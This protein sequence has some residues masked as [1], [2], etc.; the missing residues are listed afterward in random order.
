MRKESFFD[1]E[2]SSSVGAKGLMQV[3]MPTAEF[4]SKR[5][6]LDFLDISLP[7]YIHS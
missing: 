3:T 1:T 6:K 7:G 2:A 4:I 5:Y